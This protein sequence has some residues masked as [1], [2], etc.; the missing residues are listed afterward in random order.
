[1]DG[2]ALKVTPVEE[3]PVNFLTPTR[4]SRRQQGLEPAISKDSDKKKRISKEI[5]VLNRKG[6][7]GGRTH[8]SPAHGNWQYFSTTPVKKPRLLDLLPTNESHTED[9][10]IMEQ[11]SDV[12]SKNDNEIN[13]ACDGATNNVNNDIAFTYELANLKNIAHA[14]N[15]QLSCNCNIDISIS[16]FIDF[17]SSKHGMNKETLLAIANEWKT[18]HQ[19]NNKQEESIEIE[20]KCN[21]GIANTAAIVCKRCKNRTEI[22]EE[23]TKFKGKNYKGDCTSRPTYLWHKK[24]I[25]I[26]LA[27]IAT[28]MGGSETAEFLSFLNIPK[29]DA[30]AKNGFVTIEKYIG[31]CLREVSENSMKTMLEKEIE[32]TLIAK[33]IDLNNFK[34]DNSLTI[35]ITV[36]FDMGWNKRSSGNRYYHMS[37]HCFF[38]GGRTKKIY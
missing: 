35:G 18:Q 1:M 29:M 17:C 5:K 9:F 20:T 13:S 32:A 25:E 11:S 8:K 24:N 30:F 19:S 31:K 6:G 14:M 7:L 27:T 26:V 22:S 36:C 12:K 21:V 10:N 2:A 15:S 3:N 28:G 38:V 34:H 4:K 37:G 16:N 23:E 33:G